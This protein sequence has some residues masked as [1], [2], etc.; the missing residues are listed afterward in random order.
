MELERNLATPG[1]HHT[2][3]FLLSTTYRGLVKEDIHSLALDLVQRVPWSWIFRVL[4]GTPSCGREL[5]KKKKLPREL[6]SRVAAMGQVLEWAESYTPTLPWVLQVWNIWFFQ[7]SESKVYQE[8][9]NK[10]PNGMNVEVLML[11]VG[12][13]IMSLKIDNKWSLA[14]AASWERP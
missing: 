14:R 11:S 12:L 4:V 2:S 9:V 10:R 5:R 8:V 6:D 3:C 1:K 13:M 7:W